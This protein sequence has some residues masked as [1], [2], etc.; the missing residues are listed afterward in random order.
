MFVL[1]YIY[2]YIY[3]FQ[4]DFKENSTETYELAY[5]SAC[6]LIAEEKYDE[7]EKLLETAKSICREALLEEDYNEVEIEEELSIIVVQLAYVKQL[8][9]NNNQANEF[10]QSVLKIK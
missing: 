6:I 5:N 2:I 10:Y 4:D 8:K 3:I 1:I 7:A 9:G